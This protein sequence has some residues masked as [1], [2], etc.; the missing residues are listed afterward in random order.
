ML[1]A[2]TGVTPEFK[3][4]VTNNLL[5]V[6]LNYLQAALKVKPVSGKLT[7]NGRSTLCSTAITPNA[8]YAIGNGVNADFIIFIN[9][10]NET[11]TTNMAYGGAC[12]T[13]PTTD[14]YVLW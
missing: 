8:T 1:L 3:D 10:I 9:Q 12:L 11:T 2:L 5:P 6:A 4:Y 7:A 13:D 14:R